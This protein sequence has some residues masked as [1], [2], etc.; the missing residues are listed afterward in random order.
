MRAAPLPARLRLEG[1]LKMSTFL[2]PAHARAKRS[3]AKTVTWRTVASLDTFVL[4]YLI[5]GRLLFAGS[6]ASAEVVTKLLIYYFHERA[7]A[8]IPW[9][10]K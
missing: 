8:H 3:L 5:T 6:I 1:E 7:W 10:F 2:P 4:S 9:G